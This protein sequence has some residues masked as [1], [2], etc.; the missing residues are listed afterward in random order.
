ME[1]PLWQSANAWRMV[2]V[3]RGRGQPGKGSSDKGSSESVRVRFKTLGS[4]D[5]IEVFVEHSL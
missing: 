1:W 3:P 5:A 2:E 4:V